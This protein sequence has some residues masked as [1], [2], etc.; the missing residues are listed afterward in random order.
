MRGGACSGGGRGKSQE[1]QT[2]PV[3][4]NDNNG[5]AERGLNLRK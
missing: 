3:G 2:G 1:G 4:E 5:E